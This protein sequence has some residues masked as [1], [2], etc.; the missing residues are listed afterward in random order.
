METSPMIIDEKYILRPAEEKDIPSI[1]SCIREEY[2]DCYYRRAFYSEE[3]LRKTMPQ[4]NLF[5]AMD[6][7]NL[8]GF[9]SMISHMPEDEYV[10]GA[11]Q[12]FFKEYRGF[13]LSRKLVDY[14]Y[15]IARKQNFYSIYATAVTF[16]KITQSMCEKEGML[17]IGFNFGSYITSKMHNSF[18]L[19]SNE[20]YVQAILLLPLIKPE[21]KRVYIAEK[22]K[23]LAQYIY[24]NLG[25]KY[26][27]F[28]DKAEP[29]KP[30]SDIEIKVNA[31][32]QQVILR[33]NEIGVDFKEQIVEIKNKYHGELWT[34][35]LILPIEAPESVWA[36]GLLMDEGFFVSGM[37]LL[38]NKKEQ[39]FMQYI[40]DV[41]FNVEELELTDNAKALIRKILSLREEG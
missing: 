13:G 25:V 37:R 10:E 4:L 8:C 21:N 39:M 14:T 41:R 16:H 18:H 2:G 7:D 9:Q 1:I 38:C 11:S 29:E 24:D 17:P 26:Q 34:M 23:E 36:Q 30:Q 33:V 40:G 5:V 35:Q 22:T 27:I 19:G 15:D 20:K 6:G 32:E 31:R 28:T 3:Y 12:I